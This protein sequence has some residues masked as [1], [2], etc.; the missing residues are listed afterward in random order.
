[1]NRNVRQ[2]ETEVE[3]KTSEIRKK[4]SKKKDSERNIW[5]KKE[6]NCN[7]L[8]LTMNGQRKRILRKSTFL[9]TGLSASDANAAQI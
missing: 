1:M 5:N 8:E 9:P 6:I 7:V 2:A 3:R 4:N